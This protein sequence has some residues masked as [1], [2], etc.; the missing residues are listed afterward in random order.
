[1]LKPKYNPKTFFQDF[2][3]MFLVRKN[4][5]FEINPFSVVSKKAAFFPEPLFRKFSMCEKI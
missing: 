1:M 5:G 4:P 2:L 3:T